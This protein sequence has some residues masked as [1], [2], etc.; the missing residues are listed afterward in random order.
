MAMQMRETVQSGSIHQRTQVR[1]DAECRIGA[2]T[3]CLIPRSGQAVMSR[4][5]TPARMRRSET[6]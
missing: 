6:R 5:R 3:I 1:V 4:L 2:V